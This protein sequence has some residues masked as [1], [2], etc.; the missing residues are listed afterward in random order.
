MFFV[1]IFNQ[2]NISISSR[3]DCI[4]IKLDMFD[5]ALYSEWFKFPNIIS[6]E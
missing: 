4:K 5:G 6:A 1:F 3:V 2:K